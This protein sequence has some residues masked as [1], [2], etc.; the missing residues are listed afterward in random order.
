MLFK[1]DLEVM[2]I[3]KFSNF[4]DSWKNEYIYIYIFIINDLFVDQQVHRLDQGVKTY[5]HNI[6]YP[7]Y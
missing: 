3:H 5:I 1:H 2:L 4:V 7:D 6:R